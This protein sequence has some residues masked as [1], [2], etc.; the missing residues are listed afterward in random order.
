MRNAPVVPAESWREIPLA[1][2]NASLRRVVEEQWHALDDLGRIR[3]WLEGERRR[4]WR[5]A[6]DL[7]GQN[8]RLR[9]EGADLRAERD[10]LLVLLRRLEEK[11]R[12]AV[13]HAQAIEASL[14]W[15]WYDRLRRLVSSDRRIGRVLRRALGKRAVLSR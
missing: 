10:H 8:G 3:G 14:G 5:Q 1:E 12:Q 6:E 7:Q 13:D 9:K 15:Q 4:W 11:R 2:E